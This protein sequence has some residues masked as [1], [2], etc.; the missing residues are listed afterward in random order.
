VDVEA[1]KPEAVAE[2]ARAGLQ[3]RAGER[4]IEHAES[5]RSCADTSPEELEEEIRRLRRVLRET[6]GDKNL[7]LLLSGLDVL[8]KL[9][10]ARYRMSKRAERDLSQSIANVLRHYTT[11]SYGDDEL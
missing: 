6:V 9:V 5:L 8:R 2:Q 7:P 3:Y 1:E 10:L 11:H 4:A